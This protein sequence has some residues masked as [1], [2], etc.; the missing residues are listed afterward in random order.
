M[1]LKTSS[2]SPNK[3]TGRIRLPTLALKPS[4][5]FTR[6]PKQGYQWPDKK[7]SCPPKF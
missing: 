6:N 5:D 3:S 4:G 1:E 7:D 2:E